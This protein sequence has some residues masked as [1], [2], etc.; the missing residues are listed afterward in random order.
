MNTA[1]PDPSDHSIAQ[2]FREL[3]TPA[4]P[5][6]EVV[7]VRVAAVLRRAVEIDAAPAAAVGGELKTMGMVRDHFN[8]PNTPAA[9]VGGFVVGEP[10]VCLDIPDW[11]IAKS[12]RLAVEKLD[13]HVR[14]SAL[15]FASN[16]TVA[17]DHMAREVKTEYP[18][19]P[20]KLAQWLRIHH[21]SS[22]DKP[23]YRI[24]EI[25]WIYETLLHLPL[26]MTPEQQIAAQPSAKDGV[27]GEAVELTKCC[28]REECGGECGNEWRGTEWVRKATT[29]AGLV[30]GLLKQ[31]RRVRN[32]S[33]P[34]EV[35]EA[36]PVT[37]IMAEAAIGREVVG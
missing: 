1:A 2:A 32:F 15:V 3:S 5:S 37:A 33:N 12:Y 31:S 27:R 28:G 9:P 20:A 23:E 10:I 30:D 11:A 22:W 21:R 8:L 14:V 13:P 18:Y 17:A 4:Q 34:D 29:S 25:V 36:V 35:F 19:D 26:S 24:P 6:G 7:K 16:V